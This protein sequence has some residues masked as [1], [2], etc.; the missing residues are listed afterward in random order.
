MELF[1]K[2]FELTEEFNFLMFFHSRSTYG[3]FNRIFI[4]YLM[5]EYFYN[6]NNKY[7]QLLFNNF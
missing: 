5:V 3:D 4:I 7:I 6:H 2:H 1:V